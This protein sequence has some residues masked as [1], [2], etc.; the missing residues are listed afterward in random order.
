[1]TIVGKWA[2]MRDLQRIEELSTTAGLGMWADDIVLALH[3]AGDRSASEADRRLLGDAASMLDDALQQ[4]ESPLAAPRSAKGL[5]ATDTA[6]AAISSLRQRDPSE[7]ETQ[8][9]SR[10]VAVMRSLASGSS[11]AGEA[12]A[13]APLIALFG[14]VSALQLQRSNAVLASRKDDQRWTATPQTLSSS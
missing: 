11:A 5:I 2:V 4:T 12:D 3:R 8:I 13:V 6:L 9:L 7:N 14:A 1:M 10:L